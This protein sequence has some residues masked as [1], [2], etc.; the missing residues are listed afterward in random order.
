MAGNL[1]VGGILLHGGDEC[2]RPAQGRLPASISDF[3][4]W[5]LDLYRAQGGSCNGN[6]TAELEKDREESRKG[7][8]TRRNKLQGWVAVKRFI[9]P[10]GPL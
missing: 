1:G 7:A 3:G 9:N 10:G 5:I 4:F 6:D 2:F 8:K